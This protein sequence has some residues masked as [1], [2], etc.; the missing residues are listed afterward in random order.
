MVDPTFII[1]NISHEKRVEWALKFLEGDPISSEVDDE[2]FFVNLQSDDEGFD[3]TSFFELGYALTAL[4]P[5]DSNYAF[6][7]AQVLWQFD[8]EEAAIGWYSRA[9]TL[10]RAKETEHEPNKLIADEDPCRYFS[11]I[12]LFRQGMPF[13]ALLEW[14]LIES[15]EWKQSALEAMIDPSKQT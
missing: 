7:L 12:G 11:S 10:A 6:N 5:F 8:R 1:E 9:G 13:A 2:F 14:G 3:E 15:D 4:E